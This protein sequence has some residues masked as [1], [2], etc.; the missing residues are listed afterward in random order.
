MTSLYAEQTISID[1][2]PQKVWD[3]L[4]KVQYTR[5]WVNKFQPVFSSLNSDWKLGS[6]VEWQ[7]PEGKTLVDGKVTAYKPYE[8]LSYTVHDVSGSFDDVQSDEDGIFYQLKER[9]N[10]TI[11]TVKQGDFSKVGEKAQELCN[12]TVESWKRVLPVVK[13][14]AEL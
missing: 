2:S 1:A 5:Q 8:Y 14:L 13:Q 12:A 10:N 9:D 11:L 7:T 3:T 4:T 6:L